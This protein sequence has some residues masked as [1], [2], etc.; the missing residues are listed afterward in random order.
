MQ[1]FNVGKIVNTHGIRGEV[2]VISRTD[3]P[4][5]RYAV[6][7]K[8]ALFLPNEKKP[9]TLTVATHRRHK[10]FDLLTFEGH[11]NINDVEKYRDGIL[12]VSEEQLGDLEEGEFYYH[13]IIGCT[14]FT[15][16][17]EELGKV[18][19]ILETGSNDVWTVTPEKGKPHYIPYIEDVVK[20]VDIE[21]KKI[22]IE[23]MEGL[24]S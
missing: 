24:L 6:G 17:G 22:I 4:E 13:E 21:E 16:S 15:D 18:T 1:W 9:L 12:K 10:N 7:S 20:E 5:E 14:V 2:R 23:P 8:L 11:M 19:E 3:F